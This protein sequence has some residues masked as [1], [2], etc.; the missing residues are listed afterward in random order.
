MANDIDIIS[1]IT[2][3]TSQYKTYINMQ[4]LYT[5]NIVHFYLLIWGVKIDFTNNGSLEINA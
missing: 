4:I 1:S 5:L 2:R 3:D